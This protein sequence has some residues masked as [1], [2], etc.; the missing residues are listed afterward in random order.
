MKQVHPG[1]RE[2][3]F[4]DVTDCAWLLS[5]H[6]KGIKHQPFASFVLI[7]NGDAPDAIY[8]YEFPD[9]L[10]TDKPVQ[11]VSLYELEVTA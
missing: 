7:G 10:V 3:F 5:T 4:N 2:Q 8:L 9:P 6:L 1:T 11:V